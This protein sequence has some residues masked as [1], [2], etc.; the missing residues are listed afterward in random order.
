LNELVRETFGDFQAEIHER[1][2]TVKIHSL[3]FVQADH[4][5]LRQVLVNLIANA[6]KFTRHRGEAKIEVGCIPGKKNETVIFIRDNGAGFD[7]QYAHKLFGVFQRLHSAEDFEGTGIGLA[8]VQRI[9][10]RHGGRTRAEGVVNGGATFYFSIPNEN[11]PPPDNGSASK[12][13]DERPIK[14]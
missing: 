5:L 7:P 6:I 11:R 4:A 13:G 1:K 2:I 10:H 12:C 14:I 9:I 8:N 3:P